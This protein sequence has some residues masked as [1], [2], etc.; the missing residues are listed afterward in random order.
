[1]KPSISK[2]PSRQT[3]GGPVPKI[4]HSIKDLKALKRYG[5]VFTSILWLY[6]IL[7]WKWNL[8]VVRFEEGKQ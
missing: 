7:G 3:H 5:L 2:Q 4:M 6:D 8:R 1:M